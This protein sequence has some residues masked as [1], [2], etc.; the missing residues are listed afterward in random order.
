VAASSRRPRAAVTVLKLIGV[1]VAAGLLAA[2]LALPYVG[3]M[4]LVARQQSEKFLNTPC[5]LTETEPPQKTVLY[6][7]DG[8]TPIATLFYQDR[9][10]VALTQVPQFLKQAL[11]ATEDRRFY[12]HH[13]VDMRGL[14][15]GA[16]NTT[17]GDTQGGS[18]LT[19][20]YVKQ[21]RLY[22]AGDDV[23]KQQAAIDQTINRKIQDANCAI[24]LEK[25][26][27]KDQVLDKYLNIAFFGENSYGIGTAA[28]TYFN[29]DD[30]SKLTLPQAA[31][32]VGMVRAPSL[33]DPFVNPKG[34]RTRRDQVI[35][36]LV[37]VGDI[38]AAQA[39]KYE[40]TP[41][42]LGTFS[43]P[44]VRQGCAG[45]ADA[46]APIQ[47]AGF[48]CDWV[49]DWLENVGGISSTELNTGGLKITT[50]LDPNL[51][52]SLQNE[53]WSPSGVPANSP[54]TALM[55]VIDP[56]S[57]NVLAMATSK[58]YGLP[59]SPSDKTHTTI[60]MFTQAIASGASTYKLF[61]VLAALTAG[62]D[63]TTQL[64]TATSAAQYTAS[65]CPAGT[66]VKNN[67]PNISFNANESLGS[68][69]AKSSNTYFLQL[70][71]DLFGCELD[72]IVQMAQNLGM[73]DLN[74]VISA[75]TGTTVAQN[76]I[77]NH[78]TSFLIGSGVSTVPLELTNAYA[79]IA[80]DGVLHSPNPILSIKDLSNKP[81][82][83]KHG[84]P[85]KSVVTPYVARE[86]VDILIP[87]TQNGTSAPAFGT[88]YGQGGSYVAGKTGTN[89]ATDAHGQ[90]LPSN[91]SLWF[92]GATP[93]LVATTAIVN[94][95]S[96]SSPLADLPG[97]PDPTQA[98]G[99]YAAQQWVNAL[100]PTLHVQPWSWPPD[101]R[102]IVGGV[103]LP[104]LQGQTVE[105]AKATVEGLG[106][107]FVQVQPPDLQCGSTEPMGT[108]AWYSPQVAAPN[109]TVTFC[110]SSQSPLRTWAPPPP[111]RPVPRPVVPVPRRPR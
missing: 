83:Y 110:P 69:T 105:Q 51:Q 77:R 5:T 17:S 27:T 37:D 99:S 23:A 70:A 109:S 34:A 64:G 9:T 84:A 3:G 38:T 62:I 67:D 11:I 28:K 7:K 50:T 87:D 103:P 106:L 100:G 94:L 26:Y 55:P 32:L 74:R 49:V 41:I 66:Q 13:G 104:N 29:Q 81:V 107:K 90:E 73:S 52:N 39:A 15:R 40:A 68:A 42:R 31:L 76:I 19:M 8:K 80:D 58:H 95:T 21:V 45:T 10:P 72:P 1:L 53:L 60:P 16:L 2:G 82:A 20:Q 25:K 102:A 79:A 54:S 85:A 59:T 86:A 93:N 108:V 14:L 47:N 63:S 57:G 44:V 24:Q 35:Q 18:T 48:F 71:D 61:S 96:P 22:Q 12:S 43:P 36:N 101:P 56:R 89:N 91:S 4:G 92:V 78:Y 75:K 65:N 88:Y 46:R 97:V 111:P 33:Y 6:A 30:V 98:Y